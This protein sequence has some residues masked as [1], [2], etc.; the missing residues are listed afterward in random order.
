MPT[1]RYH[2]LL[3]RD[4][5]GGFSALALDDGTTGFGASAADARDDLRDY[6]RWAH[7]KEPWRTAPDFADPELRWFTVTVR[8]EYAANNRLYPSDVEV[9]VRVPC[10]VGTRASG[11][12][13]ADLPLL[14]IRFDYPGRAE[15]DKLVE[16]Y[17]SQALEGKTPEQLGAYLPPAHA[18]LL[19][20]TVSVPKDALSAA[21]SAAPPPPTLAQVAE[22]VGDRAVRKGFARAWG[23]EPELAALVRKLHHEKANVLLVGESGV[24][25]TTLMVD[26][27]KE[28]EKLALAEEEADER[29]AKYK[30]RFWLTSAGRLIAGMKYLGQWEE[31]VEAVIAELGEL[32]GVLCAERLPE[33]VRTGGHGPTDSV[34]AFLMPYLARGELRMIAEVTPAELDACRRLLPGL[35]D[36]FQIVRVEAFDRAA[37]LAVID[38]QLETAASGPGL[39]VERGTGERIVRLFRRFM[40]YAAFPGPASAFARQ[41]VDAHVRDNKKPVT[42]AAVVDRFR[43]QTGLP[44]L[45]LRDELTLSRDSVL[46][47]FRA[48]VIDQPE[49]CEAAANVVMTVKAGLNDPQ[50]PP[51]VMLFCGPTGVG[52]THMAQALASYFFGSAANPERERRGEN[53]ALGSSVSHPVAHAP[54]SPADRLIRLDMSEYGGFDAVYRLL[55]PPHGEPGPLVKQ[56]RRQ[57]FSVLL[58]DEIEK[59]AADVFDTLMGVFDEGRL[60]DQYGR[61]TNFRSTIIVMTSNL[62]AGMSRAVGFGEGAGPAYQ[63]VALKFFRP[64]FFNRM[65][66]V[67]TFRPLLPPAVKAITRRELDAI[68]KREGLLRAGVSVR[69]SEALVDH[70]AAVGFDPRYGAR[71]LQR[72]IEREVVAGLARWLLAHE[73][74]EGTTIQADWREG[75]CV[76]AG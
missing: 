9:G 25:K 53:S 34:A 10:V 26:A 31:R 8:P 30:R 67:V 40:P 43:K 12:H 60:T 52:K 45:F 28:A 72:A 68:A 62:G 73:I 4:A 61:V 48:R 49:A 36:L 1:V 5:A 71:P 35:P 41:I 33:L 56:V 75:A 11:Q 29:R 47:W 76:F 58:L 63:D 3:C 46:D 32:D 44:E 22:P 13:A 39:D 38:K 42:P 66:A 20:L 27:V 57:P 37:A 17:V 23:R 16:R 24:G 54:G 7:R 2:A 14:G 6:L 15:L 69:W 74:S 21:E 65:D 59:T 70:L 18:E 51:A 19:E 64:E 55:G 50:R